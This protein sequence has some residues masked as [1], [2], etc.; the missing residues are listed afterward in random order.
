M[1]ASVECQTVQ[2]LGNIF[3][4]PIYKITPFDKDSRFY[5]AVTEYGNMCLIIE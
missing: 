5:Q 2:G 4:I 1:P 3:N